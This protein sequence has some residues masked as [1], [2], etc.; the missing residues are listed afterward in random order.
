MRKTPRSWRTFGSTQYHPLR[1]EL[2][3]RGPICKRTEEQS[4]LYLRNFLLFRPDQHKVPHVTMWGSN[5]LFHIRLPSTSSRLPPSITRRLSTCLHQLVPINFSIS[6]CPYQLVSINLCL[7][8]C[9]YPLVSI[10]LS[11]STCLYQLVSI[12]LS[13]PCL[14]HLV[15]IQLSLSPCLYP[16]VSITLSSPCLFHLVYIHLSLSP[17]LHLVSITLSTSTCT[18]LQLQQQ[19]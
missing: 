7:S 15:I 14:Y 18:T 10:N 13:S 4:G 6:T 12:T 5:F 2:W 19:L 9:L 3:V 8:T 1:A 16:L 11:I 17:F